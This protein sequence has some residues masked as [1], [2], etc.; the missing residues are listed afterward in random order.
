MTFLKFKATQIF[1]IFSGGAIGFMPLIKTDDED[2]VTNLVITRD[3]LQN[4]F[5][6]FSS[7]P[8]LDSI[9]IPSAITL[10]NEIQLLIV[11]ETID[12]EEVSK[13]TPI[14]ESQIGQIY[15]KADFFKNSVFGLDAK[16]KFIFNREIDGVP[17]AWAN[18]GLTGTIVTSTETGESKLVVLGLNKEIFPVSSVVNP[19]LQLSIFT[20]DILATL[21][22]IDQQMMIFQQRLHVF[23][24]NVANLPRLVICVELKVSIRLTYCLLLL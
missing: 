13:V 19:E 8:S 23:H 16:T 10:L 22:S 1:I 7:T 11:E 4:G 6:T 12:D 18:T 3:S 21:L 17:G 9:E 24:I 14:A 15:A 5:T 20:W 2:R